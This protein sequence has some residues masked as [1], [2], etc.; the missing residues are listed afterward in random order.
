VSANF[1]TTQWTL[2]WKAAKEDSQAG[3]PALT[4]VIRR[5]W[6]PLY[7]F[8]RRRGMSSEDAEDATQ[9]FLSRIVD[10]NLLQQADP[11]QG[12]FRTYLLAAWKRFLIDDFR[13]RNTIRR[14][15][16]WKP[17]SLDF[18]SVEQH[19]QHL[20]SRE[21]DP[22]RVFMLAWANS[23]LESARERI[24][25][26]YRRSGRELICQTLLDKLSVG[27]DAEAYRQLGIQTGLTPNA[28]KVALHRLRGRFAACLRQ[29]IAE[30]VED[31]AE[32]DTELR[33]MLAILSQK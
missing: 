15:G 7:S 11:A 17:A 6:Q 24:S 29:V 1:A 9:E 19:W 32:I 18:A 26:E 3:R 4:E 30:T 10:G 22:D 20:Q 33:E 16:Q 21:P 5:Y 13:R 25:E 14:G 23:L 2:V 31:P 8:A 28:V 12:K 27:L